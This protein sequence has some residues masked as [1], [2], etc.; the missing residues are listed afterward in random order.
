[1]MNVIHSEWCKI[2]GHRWATGLLLW[3]YP[4]GALCLSIIIIVAALIAPNDSLEFGLGQ[5]NWTQSSISVWGYSNNL[6]GRLL[7]FGFAAVIFGNEYSGKTWKN[8]IPRASRTKLLLTKFIIL[9]LL[10]IIAL[11]LT[12]LIWAVGLSLAT[13]V[14][15]GTISPELSTKNLF[16]FLSLYT[17]HLGLALLSLALATSYASLGSLLTHST[18]GT[19]LVGLGL[20]IGEEFSQIFFSLLTL[21]TDN[22]APLSLYRFMPTYCFSNLSSWINNNA[23]MPIGGTEF[24]GAPFFVSLIVLLFWIGGIAA[25]CIVLFRRQDIYE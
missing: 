21:L 24:S 6:V 15:G 13:K 14:A 8:L 11:S 9:P 5:I 1:M 19:L 4:I 16:D 22:K 3:V 23:A 20:T 7:L 2:I 25:I 12:S 10:M 18:V 17:N